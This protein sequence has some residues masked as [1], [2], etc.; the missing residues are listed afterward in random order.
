MYVYV[1][2]NKTHEEFAKDQLQNAMN[3]IRYLIQ[4]EDE[5]IILTNFNRNNSNG[6][7]SEITNRFI[8]E[9]L[10]SNGKQLLQFH[11]H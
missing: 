2:T 8:E 5:G 4:L 6:I 7:I 10:N 11:T 3:K 9:I 1:D